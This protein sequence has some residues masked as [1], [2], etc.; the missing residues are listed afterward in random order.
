MSGESL[1][2]GVGENLEGDN[3]E[4]SKMVLYARNKEQYDIKQA[5]LEELIN[6]ADQAFNR[7]Q[8]NESRR[9]L[10]ERISRLYCIKGYSTVQYLASQG[11][12]L[13]GDNPSLVSEWI[14]RCKEE[15]KKIIESGVLHTSGWFMKAALDVMGLMEE[16]VSDKELN[17]CIDDLGV[18]PEAVLKIARLVAHFGSKGQ[19]FADAVGLGSLPQELEDY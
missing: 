9:K 6:T 13:I 4:V 11:E 2:T 8:D 10:R 5:E 15:E 19:D 1:S 12:L 14:G 16:G 18:P 17:A 7:T 3:P